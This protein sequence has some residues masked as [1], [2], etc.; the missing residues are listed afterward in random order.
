MVMKV[1]ETPGRMFFTP[2][3]LE[4]R[5]L[6]RLLYFETKTSS[7][8]RKPNAETNSDLGVGY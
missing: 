1:R 2:T 8:N 4:V 5:L 3:L 6:H 7:D